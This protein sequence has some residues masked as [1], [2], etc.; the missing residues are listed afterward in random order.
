MIRKSYAKVNIFLKI[1]GKNGAYHNIASRFI[2]VKDLFDI[3]E[4]I[5][6]KSNVFVIE[7]EF[8]CTV[9]DNLI[10]KGYQALSSKYPKVIEFFRYHK[11]VV[12]KNI[13]SFAG[14]GGGS[15]NCAVFLN[16]CNDIL[17]LNIPKDK[18]AV[19]GKTLGAD[20]PFFVYE[21]NSA[22]VSG[23]GD[24]VEEFEEEPLGIVTFTPSIKCSTKDIFT[25]FRDKFYTTILANEQEMLFGQSSKEI[26]DSYDIFYLNDLYRSVLSIEPQFEQIYQDLS[27]DKKI[28]FSGSGSSFFWLK[29]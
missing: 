26:L 9:E 4:F 10:Y 7:G 29:E 1:V 15:S 16:M 11:V 12:K 5:P 19:I 21:Y 23:I 13:P 20:V 24:I 6:H 3:I 17:N 25:T 28:F 14:L 22:N 8:D 18:L 27:L 2:L